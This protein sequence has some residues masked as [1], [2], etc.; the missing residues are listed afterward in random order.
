M[1][2]YARCYGRGAL[3]AVALGALGAEELG[4]L[5]IQ[6]EHAGDHLAH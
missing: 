3:G 1:D 5:R 6:P 4:E 2:R